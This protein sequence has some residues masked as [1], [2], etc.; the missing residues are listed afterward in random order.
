MGIKIGVNDKVLICCFTIYITII[1][2]RVKDSLIGYSFS[3]DFKRCWDRL[4]S[5]CSYGL[6]N[7]KKTT[8]A[9]NKPFF[10]TII[11]S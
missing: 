3:F 7:I 11:K 8:M 10:I 1:M 4:S 6:S 9:I 5:L 2:V